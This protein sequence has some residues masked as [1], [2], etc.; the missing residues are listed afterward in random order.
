M[1]PGTQ[2]TLF[3]WWRP[4]NWLR[5]V[6]GVWADQ[7]WYWQ[8]VRPRMGDW[9]RGWRIYLQAMLGTAL[10]ALALLALL[11]GLLS[12]AGVSV[13][14]TL[15]ILTLGVSLALG[16][17][18]GLLGK[19]SVAVVRG[20]IVG[21]AVSLFGSFFFALDIGADS[22]NPLSLLPSLGWGGFI[23]LTLG[24]AFSMQ[25]SLIKGVRYGLVGSVKA[26]VERSALVGLLIGLDLLGNT[27]IAGGV[28]A[29]A[30]S[31]LG[32]YLSQLWATRQ[33]SD[34][35]TRRGLADPDRVPVE[36]TLDA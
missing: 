24:V 9:G 19:A 6:Y 10:V 23:G 35:Q 11:G 2:D 14:W 27:G 17:L 13:N 18:A 22:E 21:L 1:N 3:Q 20:V 34:D 30:A 33:V 26:N 36:D 5:L 25:D 31:L 15:L 32:A 7:L 16:L 29:A 12:A 4:G 28:A 8:N